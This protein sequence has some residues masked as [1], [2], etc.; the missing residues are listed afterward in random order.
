MFINNLEKIYNSSTNYP[1]VKKKNEWCK[2][3]CPPGMKEKEKNIRFREDYWDKL[4]KEEQNAL[5]KQNHDYA[6]SKNLHDQNEMIEAFSKSRHSYKD[7]YNIA[8]KSYNDLKRQR[9]KAQIEEV[10]KVTF[11]SSSEYSKRKKLQE[12]ALKIAAKAISDKFQTNCEQ[13]SLSF[14]TEGKNDQL[15]RDVSVMLHQT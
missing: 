14:L 9:P 3:N 13:G 10:P 1:I 2:Q 12:K 7:Y 15:G 4:T 8:K 6:T 5:L 11:T